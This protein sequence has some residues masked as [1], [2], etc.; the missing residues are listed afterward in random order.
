[1]AS[2]ETA[3]VFLKTECRLDAWYKTGFLRNRV[4]TYYRLEG[5]DSF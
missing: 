3:Q 5:R 2:L 1:M 4:M